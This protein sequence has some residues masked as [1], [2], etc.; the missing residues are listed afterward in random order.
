MCTKDASDQFLYFKRKAAFDVSCSV[1]YPSYGHPKR[2]HVLF[3]G[4]L[5]FY[6]TLLRTSDANVA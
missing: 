4:G 5:G 1:T 3:M 2:F 6:I